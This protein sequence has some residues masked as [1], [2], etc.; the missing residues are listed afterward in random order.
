MTSYAKMSPRPIVCRGVDQAP[1]AVP[2]LKLFLCAWLHGLQLMCDV[3]HLT[4]LSEI[5]PPIPDTCISL[6]IVKCGVVVVYVLGADLFWISGVHS[7]GITLLS[8]SCAFA[9]EIHTVH[10]W[11]IHPK[12]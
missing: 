9:A 5:I 8:D 1:A 11:S 6:A 2:T 3:P 10:T 4:K 12:L 7:A